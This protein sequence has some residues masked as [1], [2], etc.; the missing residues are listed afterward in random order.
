MWWLRLVKITNFFFTLVNDKN[1]Q[2]ILSQAYRMLVIK[3]K[4][5]GDSVKFA[6]TLLC[7]LPLTHYGWL[8]IITCLL[9]ACCDNLPKLTGLPGLVR[10]WLLDQRHL[11]SCS[12]SLT[13]LIHNTLT[14]P[15]LKVSLTRNPVVPRCLA[16]LMQLSMHDTLQLAL[17]QMQ[18]ACGGDS[19]C[20]HSIFVT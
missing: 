9:Y 8:S 6:I 10:Q 19:Y 14:H 12:L 17:N 15:S 20:S 13:W 2:I 4:S 1:C 5:T 11:N 16:Y 7:L 3:L 18:R